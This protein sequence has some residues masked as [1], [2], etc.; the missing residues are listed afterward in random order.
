MA[1]SRGNSSPLRPQNGAAAFNVEH[2]R[3]PAVEHKR[4][5]IMLT[6]VIERGAITAGARAEITVTSPR[7]DVT[8]CTFA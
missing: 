8:H 7:G 2:D 4:D 6:V 5:A 3:V 1:R